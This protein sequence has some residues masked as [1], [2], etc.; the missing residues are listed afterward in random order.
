[1][2]FTKSLITSLGPTKYQQNASAA[3]SNKQFIGQDSNAIAKLL[4]RLDLLNFVPSSW[5]A[6]AAMC[7][8]DAAKGC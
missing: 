2:S 3:K 8:R 7:A 6:H 1:M 4:Q 5:Q